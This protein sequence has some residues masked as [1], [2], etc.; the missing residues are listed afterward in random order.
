[1]ARTE[2]LFRAGE[3]AQM[4]GVS[5]AHFYALLGAGRLPPADVLLPGIEAGRELRRWSAS[6]L[7][8]WIDS[9]RTT[10]RPRSS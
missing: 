4:L 10:P 5:R 3:A 8:Q 9:R 1:M 6:A 2:Q 7:E